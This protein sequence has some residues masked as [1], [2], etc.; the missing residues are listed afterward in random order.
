MKRTNTL[1]GF[2]LIEFVDSYGRDCSLQE[3]S[4]IEPHVWLG[5]WHANPK[6]MASQAAALGIATEETTGWVPYPVPSEVMMTTRMHL[7]RRQCVRVALALLWFALT[8]RLPGRV[9]P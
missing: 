8:C 7:N 4:N 6:I 1:R 9:K 2:G 5:P 3:S